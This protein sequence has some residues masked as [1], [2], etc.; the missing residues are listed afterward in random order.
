MGGNA[1]GIAAS[2]GN[3]PGRFVGDQAEP[4]RDQVNAP[5]IL[6]AIMTPEPSPVRGIRTTA[7]HAGESP[8]PVTGASAPSIVMSTAFVADAGVSFSAED[9]GD[10]TPYLYTR[11]KNPT[12]DQLEK[13]LAALEGAGGSV[14]FASGMAAV[15]ALLLYTLRAGDHLVI[16]DISYAATAEMTNELLPRLGIGVTKV[17]MS[18]PANVKAAL[19]PNTK[20]VYAESP[21]NPILRLTDLEAVGRI[22][23]EKGARFAVDATFASP[24]GIQPTQLGADFVLHSLTKYINGHG[25]AIGGAVIGSAQDMAAIKKEIA[26]RT[27]GILSPFNAWLIQRGAA[28]L[29]LRM[30]A[31]EEGAHAVAQF[32]EEHPKVTRVIYPGLPSHP[33]Y[34]LAQK[35]LKNTSGMITFQV[36]DGL[37]AAPVIA[38]RLSVIHY[39][40]SLGHQRSLVF[41]LPTRDMLRTSFKLTPAQEQSFR[42]FAGDGIF[43]LSVGL[44]DPADLIADLAHALD[45]I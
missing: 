24:I 28:T 32:L 10:N 19:R 4:T 11:W 33:Q 44:E 37:A 13:K 22:A 17:D 14:A 16:S 1:A 8:D 7:I 40:V 35:Q 29:P 2:G 12:V 20:L 3:N 27:G 42:A 31:H 45:G 43:R 25:D 23:H 34:A 9:F 5:G 21:A 6:D 39:A 38:K 41:Y 36:K 15:T 26:I 30:R 18:D